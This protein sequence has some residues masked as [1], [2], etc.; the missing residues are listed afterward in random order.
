[1]NLQFPFNSVSGDR[2]YDA[3]DVAQMLAAVLTNGVHPMPGNCLQ[4]AADEG[5]TVTLRAGSCII[6]GRLGVNGADT[7]ITL[8]DPDANQPR[9]D[10]VVLRLDTFERSITEMALTGSPASSPIPAELTREGDIYEL[11]VAHILVNPSDEG[12]S[13]NAIT[14]TRQNTQLCGIVT[15]LVQVDPTDLFIQYDAIFTEWYANTT[16]NAESWQSTRQN[17]FDEWF[18]GLQALLD[19]NAEAQIAQ[20]I[21]SLDARLDDVELNQMTG[22]FEVTRFTGSIP[23]SAW[24]ENEDIGLWQTDIESEYVNEDSTVI[25]TLAP[26]SLRQPVGAAGGTS[27]GVFRLYAYDLPDDEVFYTAVVQ[28]VGG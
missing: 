26:E 28:K 10:S 6:N 18:A 19:G 13:Q 21:E 4:V 7:Q 12:I 27:D 23:T 24:E 1:M 22:V 8:E 14:D 11:C 2:V 20:G 17:Q 5:F 16:Q 3:D 9:V 25:V 15:S